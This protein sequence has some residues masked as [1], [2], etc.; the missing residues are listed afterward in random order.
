MRPINW[1]LKFL[2]ITIS[3]S[4]A[5]SVFA[6]FEIQCQGNNCTYPPML[7]VSQLNLTNFTRFEISGLTDELFI[8]APTSQTPRDF[9]SYVLTRN[10]AGE[11]ITVDVQSRKEDAPAAN[12]VFVG[13]SIK[14]MTI[15]TNGFNGNNYLNA[16]RLCAKNILEDQYSAQIKS[17]FLARRV[18]DPLL[19]SNTCDLVDLASIQSLGGVSCDP[20]FSV[21]PTPNVSGTRW[22]PKR[23]CKTIAGRAMCVERSL[24]LRCD[25]FNDRTSSGCCV[26]GVNTPAAQVGLPAW[27]CNPARCSATE[28]G[29]YRRYTFR[30]TE[31]EYESQRVSG[32]SD[33]FM[34]ETKISAAGNSS[35]TDNYYLRAKYY[36]TNTT[37]AGDANDFK[38]IAPTDETFVS[39]QYAAGE[40]G[41]YDDG[42]TDP[43]V[44]SHH[45]FSDYSQFVSPGDADFFGPSGD[46]KDHIRLKGN[47]HKIKCT[48]T[49]SNYPIGSEC[50]NRL[51]PLSD[52]NICTGNYSSYLPGNQCW[53]ELLPVCTNPY[54]TYP[55]GSYCYNMQIDKNCTGAF[56]SYPSTG[57]GSFCHKK[58]KEQSCGG[59]YT[60][61]L[62]GS[63]CWSSLQ[64]NCT[65]PSSN[66]SV[67]S[68]CW[69]KQ[70]P[71]CAPGGG[72]PVTPD[73][74]FCDSY[75]DTY[76]RNDTCSGNYTDYPVGH[77][78]WEQRQPTC[79]GVYTSYPQNSFCYN[80]L[81]PACPGVYTDYPNGSYCYQKLTPY[82]CTG[83]FSS[84]PDGS[85]CHVQLRPACSGVYTDYVEGSYC[86]NKLVPACSG[87]YTD[88]A[89]GSYCRRKLSPGICEGNYTD[90]QTGSFCWEDLQ[91]ECDG[92]YTD[93]TVGSYCYNNLYPGQD[94]SMSDAY[95]CGLNSGEGS[96]C[97]R[98]SFGACEL[99]P[100]DPPHL[101][102]SY[103][104]RR[105][106]AQT[107]GYCEGGYS[108]FPKGSY[109]WIERRALPN[110]FYY[111]PTSCAVKCS[112]T[113][114]DVLCTLGTPS[115]SD[116]HVPTVATP[117]GS[118]VHKDGFASF[119]VRIKT[120][121]GAGLEKNHDTEVQIR[122]KALTP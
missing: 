96:L 55:V 27:Q 67:G 64:P 1:V 75:L 2:V 7:P 14:K 15:N 42:F 63:L 41:S 40:C 12:F 117:I 22:K 54:N 38:I 4:L 85:F 19:P 73:E 78:C 76:Q 18:S 72:T 35:N 109:C 69:H 62:P 6:Q 48:G 51:L 93:F 32:F 106:R 101:E 50:Y 13:D 23:E 43:D 86:Y 47:G 82:I 111:S 92:N 29:W 59:V 71:I 53:S 10:I 61:Y 21:L 89:I 20:G 60:D 88:Y 95:N 57:V 108:D 70:A 102:G 122:V 121:N 99:N 52:I 74:I 116:E 49:H 68:Y 81:A 84:Y 58:L 25:A 5:Q 8:T 100:G 56:T 36:E 83:N 103:C 110:P 80:K 114:N 77:K 91:P 104:W 87:A 44:N 30:M 90:Y 98:E 79:P 45:V 97:W 3:L 118:R 37:Y 33:E 119:K 24:T 9:R 120:M 107:N 105:Q 26:P 46:G 11:D 16:S 94:P 17:A 113:G 34:C 28:S 66:Y 65:G 31:T 112:A 115:E 39:F